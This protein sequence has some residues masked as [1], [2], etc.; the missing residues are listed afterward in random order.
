MDNENKTA[1]C[2][3]PSFVGG[4]SGLAGLAS[5]M[6]KW[7]EIADSEKIERMREII[8]GQGFALS[9][10]Q[11]RIHNL[12]VKLKNHQHQDGKV[13]EVKE[14]QEYDDSVKVGLMG[15]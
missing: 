13:V 10:A 9:Q 12:R 3:T 7:S 15:S 5:S 2:V 6:K 8:K 4:P 11:E 1:G 14:V